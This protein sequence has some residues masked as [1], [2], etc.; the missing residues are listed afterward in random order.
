[1]SIVQ[2]NHF[3]TLKIRINCWVMGDHLNLALSLCTDNELLCLVGS[4][5][6]YWRCFSRCVEQM[7]ESAIHH[8]IFFGSLKFLQRHSVKLQMMWFLCH[9]IWDICS[10]LLSFLPFLLLLYSSK[11]DRKTIISF[12]LVCDSR[13]HHSRD[14]FVDRSL[15]I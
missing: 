15:V 2:P 9:W 5:D 13:K 4:S 12:I 11:L 10:V 1:M 8:G 6:G 7:E 3:S 14:N